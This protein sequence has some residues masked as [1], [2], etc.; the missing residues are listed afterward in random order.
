MSSGKLSISVIE[1]K[2]IQSIILN[3]IKA[4]KFKE[5]I[6]DAVNL[7]EK[8]PYNEYLASIDLTLIKDVLFSQGFYFAKVKSS[9]IEN[10]NNTVDLIYDVE[11][12][13]KV[14]VKS[15]EFTW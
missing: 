3:G 15:I 12:G 13:D 9:I 7:K 10:T 4:T 2:I 6:L 11:M 5:A 8:S 14:K 1:N